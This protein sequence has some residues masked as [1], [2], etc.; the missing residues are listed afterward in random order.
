MKETNE[1]LRDFTMTNTPPPSVTPRPS[2]PALPSPGSKDFTP[3][4]TPPP[5][6][7]KKN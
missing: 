2:A 3:Q 5:P 1:T 4:N 7:P 6:P